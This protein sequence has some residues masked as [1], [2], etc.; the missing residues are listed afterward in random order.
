MGICG[1]KYLPGC[2]VTGWALGR[3]EGPPPLFWVRKIQK[4]VLEVDWMVISGYLPLQR[5]REG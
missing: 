5:A 3:K 2:R 4:N 1:L